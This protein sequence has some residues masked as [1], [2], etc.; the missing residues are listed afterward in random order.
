MPDSIEDYR[1]LIEQPWGKMFYDM[2]FRQLDLSKDKKLK[3]LDYGAGFCV[4][5]RYYAE[6]HNV[7]AYEPNPEMFEKRVEGDYKLITTQND[8]KILEEHSFDV[9]I[10]HNVLEYV[11]SPTEI[12]NELIKY[13]KPN[14]ILS[15]VKHNLKGRI[16]AQ[17]IYSDDPAGALSLL[18]SQSD[19]GN[20]LFGKRGTYD[21]E[22]LLRFAESNGL[23]CKDIF[24]IRTFFAVSANFEIKYTEEWYKG[25]LELEMQTCDI[26]EY[27]NV[28]FFHHL[29]FKK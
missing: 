22:M 7:T 14:G 11:S 20:N 16:L 5:A 8:F 9:V 29:I 26:D 4:T 17:A 18:K 12:L 1:N 25:M 10:C 28:S 15:I 21:N 27:K 23:V 13:L 24:G 2:I 19:N 3:I 6:S